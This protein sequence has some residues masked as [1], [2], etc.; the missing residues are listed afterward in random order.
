MSTRSP[1]LMLISLLYLATPG[2][3]MSMVAGETPGVVSNS[4]CSQVFLS[5]SSTLSKTQSG[6]LGIY[7]ITSQ[8]IANN[9]HPVYIKQNKDQDFYLYFRQNGI[10]S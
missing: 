3:W 7:S 8:K 2:T 10:Q 1:L 5:S 9:P 4:C 6:V